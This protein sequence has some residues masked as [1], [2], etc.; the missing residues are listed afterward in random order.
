M[1]LF[2]W[3]TF[4]VVM[5]VAIAIAGPAVVATAADPLE[6]PV[7]LSMTGAGTFIG[8]E[9]WQ[10]IGIAETTINKSGG[11]NG[12]P[13]KFV[14]KDDQSN[15]QNDIQLTQALISAKAQIVIGPTTTASCNAIMP[16]VVQN[17]PVMYC[18]TAGARPEPRGFVFSTLTSTPDLIA[19]AI[20]YFRDRGFKKMAYII[21][22]DA[23]GQDAEQGI[24]S[25]AALPEN[26]TV[27]LV[28]REHFA[29]ADISISAQLSKIKAAEPEV[30]LT[31]A[32]GT[33]G[34]TVLRGLHD[35]G[36]TLPTLL[37]PANMTGP[38]T[39]QFGPSMSDTMF[40]PGMAYYG[41]TSS[42]DAK[43]RNAMNVMTAAYRGTGA[44][45]DQVAIS[46]WDPTMFV[47][48]TL[49]KVGVDAPSTKIRDAMISAKGW[50]G[51]NGPYDFGAYAQRGIGQS[52]IV[53]VRWDAA[54]NDFVPSSRL[55]GAPLRPR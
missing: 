21:T 38:F 36:I 49:R 8:Q 44:S 4:A 22:T 23:S 27:E 43:T 5:S 52:A 24:L 3:I 26:K 16:L 1:K 29:P 40:L 32:S 18:L 17:G 28:A 46:A 37:S 6:I 41:G 19:V 11:I 12:R 45:V 10:A 13:V 53:M 50:V 20:R 48:D 7:I 30:V 42:V 33:A 51:V 14:M 54:K 47:V 15:P 31:W 34:G 55:G 2:R 35:A 39:K 9:Q 25:A